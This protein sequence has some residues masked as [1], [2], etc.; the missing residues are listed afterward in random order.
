LEHLHI[1]V[2]AFPDYDSET[3]FFLQLITGREGGAVKHR[4]LWEKETEDFW[5]ITTREASLTFPKGRA[6]TQP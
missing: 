2:D 6:I 5:M 3:V 1:E 4:F